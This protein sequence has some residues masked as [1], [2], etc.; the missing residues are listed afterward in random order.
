MMN[1]NPPPTIVQREPPIADGITS[2]YCS[3]YIL[4]DTNLDRGVEK[5]EAIIMEKNIVEIIN[6]VF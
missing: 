5:I 3:M 6:V 2:S 1:S 4:S